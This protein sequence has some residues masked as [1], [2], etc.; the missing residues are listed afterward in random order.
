MSDSPDDQI[1]ADSTTSTFTSALWFNAAIGIGL[2]GVFSIL[3]TRRPQTY[4]P[5]LYAVDKSHRPPQLSRGWFLWIYQLFKIPDEDLIRYMGLD[6]FMIL[7]F[8]RMGM[9]V[10]S[11]FSIL[12]IPI[13][14]PLNIINQNNSPGL[15]ILTMGN[16]KDSQ[17]TWAHL[18]LSIVLTVGVIYYTYRETRKYIKLRRSLLLSPDYA[19]SVVARTIFIPSIP[20][21][22]NNID[23]LK[24]IFDKFPGGVRRVWLNRDVK[25]LPDKVA[26]R[27][28]NVQKLETAVTKAILASYK[29]H[30]KKDIPLE[31]GT[32]PGIPEKLRPTHRVSPLPIPIPCI[33]RKVDSLNY[34]R[35]QI[36]DLNEEISAEQRA[37]T[38]YRQYNS[39]FIEF[40]S[41]VAAHMAAQTLIHHKELSMEPRYIQISPDDIIWENMGIRP[42]ERLVRRV[43]SIGITTAIVIFWA[44]PV[45]FIQLVA[46]I[47]A[48]AKVLP[49]LK[50]MESWSPT[51]VGIIQGILP[52]VALAI[53]IGLVPVI[54]AWLSKME[55]I[56]QK[57]FVQLSLLHKYFFFQF[58]DVVLVSTIA[59]GVIQAY[60][61][62]IQNPLSIVNTLAENL[63]K[64]STFFITFVMLQATNGS[65]QAILQAVP[66]ILSYVFPFL[67]TTPR[68]IYRAKVT[69][70]NIN[71]GTL[72]PSQSVI[73]ILGLE[74]AVIAPLILPFVCLYFYLQYF[75]YLY[76]FLYVYEM[77]YETFGRAFPRAIRHVYIG[78]FTWQLTMIGLFVLQG[79]AIPQLV[80]MIITLVV[81]CCALYLYDISFQPLFKYLPVETINI[82]EAKK[83]ESQLF[84]DNSKDQMVKAGESSKDEDRKA[85]TEVDASDSSSSR[86]TADSNGLHHRTTARSSAENDEDALLKSVDAYAVRDKLSN[87]I[88]VKAKHIE[89]SRNPDDTKKDEQSFVKT[90]KDMYEVV[91]YMNPALTAM[92][93]IVWLPQDELG[94]TQ[95]TMEQLQADNIHTSDRSATCFQ[96]KKGKGKV[97][98]DEQRL[99]WD[100]EGMPGSPR[101]TGQLSKVND[102]VRVVADNYNVV[103]ALGV[104]L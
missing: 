52:A 32:T 81:S 20:A 12:A 85:L 58:V 51:I 16:I 19:K 28:Q 57:S 27:G 1:N 31:E 65:A 96:Y 37:S 59:G 29:Y 48:L 100:G 103:D 41:Q 14:I 77:Q 75:V 74:Y 70:Q 33:G 30:A 35:E 56:P 26:D 8:L 99:V 21:R 43:I 54:F 38:R 18:I 4:E 40:N 83:R 78:M 102:F 53:L 7:K 64:A 67:W 61:K 76:Q 17:R 92:Q 72:I 13:L 55:G 82:E 42:Y 90:A 46:N 24:G 80:I 5:R 2:F 47:D 34:Y 39:A 68:D 6:R 84:N 86:F 62:I 93:P 87:T 36:R 97:R 45:V 63:P 101:N 73:F 22:V 44:I 3:R 98:I 15:N 71:L 104:S 94:I 11:L 49:F 9:V 23:D 66:F 10:F 25:K 95:N 79:D 89:D 69:L 88:D 60:S 91:S 50:P